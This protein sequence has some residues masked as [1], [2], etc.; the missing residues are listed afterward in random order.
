MWE[1]GALIDMNQYKLTFTKVRATEP[2]KRI[3]EDFE[4]HLFENITD[5]LKWLQSDLAISCMP[6]FDIERINNNKLI[7]VFYNTKKSRKYG[8]IDYYVEIKRVKVDYMRQI[9]RYKQKGF[10]DEQIK[11]MQKQEYYLLSLSNLNGA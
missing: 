8:T 5:C 6:F 11:S 2:N 7:K 1:Y 4:F 10:N 3:I 9:N